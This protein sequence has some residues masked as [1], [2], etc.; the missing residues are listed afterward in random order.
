MGL[1]VFSLLIS[2]VMIERI[3]ILCLIII[4]QSEV[5]TI[6]HCLVFGHETMVCT[7]CLSIFLWC[8]RTAP[9]I[10]V[11]RYTWSRCNSYCDTL[12]TILSMIWYLRYIFLTF[13][14]YRNC[15]LV[16]ETWETEFMV[17]LVT[18]CSVI[19]FSEIKIYKSFTVLKWVTSDV[20]VLRS[21]LHWCFYL[22][23]LYSRPGP[24]WL[25]VWF[26]PL[27]QV[28]FVSIQAPVIWYVY[29]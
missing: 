29:G 19:Y 18:L 3:Y 8:V 14:S 16:K 2:L 1:C 21:L 15:Q 17:R 12:L 6:I 13:Y 24:V 5:W 7:V 4:I 25:S 27:E 10:G 28:S 11:K 9:G 22:L 20:F 26:L 23:I